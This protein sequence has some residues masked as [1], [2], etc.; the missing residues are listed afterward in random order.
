MDHSIDVVDEPSSI[1][2]S[3][4]IQ[5]LSALTLYH[6]MTVSPQRLIHDFALQGEEPSTEYLVR[7][8]RDIGFRARLFTATWAEALRLGEALPALIRLTNGRTAVLLGFDGPDGAEHAIVLDPSATVSEPLRADRDR[9]CAQWTGEVILAKPRHALTDETQPFGLKW[10]IPEIL[11]ER[12][13]FVDIAVIAM[14]LHVLALAVPMFFQLVID[15]VLVHQTVATLQV[16]SVGIVTVLLF[17]FAFKFIR[18][19][20]LIFATQKIDIRIMQRTFSHLIKMPIDLF[21]RSSAGV[22]VKHMQQSEQ[23]REFLTGKLFLTIL[24]LTSLL[25]FVPILLFYSVE[26]SLVVISISLIIAAIIFGMMGPFRKRLQ[27]LYDAEGARQALLVETIH[28]MRTVKSLA[29]E[30]RQQMEWERR[31]SAAVKMHFRVAQLSNVAQT[32][33]ELLEKIMTVMVV[34]VGTF[35][36]FGGTMT[37]GAL[38]AFQMISG[39]VTGPLVQ[40]VSLV[41]QYQETALSVR[42]LG[43]IMNRPTE[44]LNTGSLAP[45]LQGKIEFDDLTFQ[46]PGSTQA[47]LSHVSFVVEANSIFGVVGRSGS[48]KTTLTRLLQRLYHVHDGLIRLDGVDMREIDLVHLRQSLGVVLQESFLFRGTIRS[49]IAMTKSNAT[50]AEIMR[51]ARLAGADEFI[52]RLPQG[53][54]TPLEENAA[55]LSGGQKQRIAIA[56][57]LLPD[58]KILILDE[59]TSSLDPESEAIVQ[60]NLRDIAAGRTLVI[61]SHRLSSLVQADNILVLDKGEKAGFGSHESLLKECDIYRSLW[62]QQTRHMT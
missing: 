36:V 23:I 1:A 38:I 3:T 53:L 8:A 16:L 61:V 10:F 48:G 57:A 52:Q 44:Q 43:A 45:E 29:V 46:Y 59:A 39:R 51:A 12:R 27:D 37:V 58:P 18:Q 35:A 32:T 11:R 26:L 60:Q 20:L 14:V 4:A 21:E 25:V 34:I 19:Y 42:M 30:P 31:A 54:D 56:R 50:P 17:D 33:T 22:L 5:C 9:F 28:G 49:N 40:V 6:Q 62:Q 41:H 55:N 24:D 15:R 47:A 2:P 13:A 7:I